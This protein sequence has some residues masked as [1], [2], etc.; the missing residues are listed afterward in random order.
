V[1]TVVA[2]GIWGYLLGAWVGRIHARR[3]PN[4]SDAPPIRLV[5]DSQL[6]EVIG[7][8][9]LVAL[10]VIYRA[11]ALTGANREDQSGYV[12][13]VAQLLIPAYLL[14]LAA[15]R[16][17]VPRGV[18]IRAALAGLAL[19]ASG[20][21]TYTLVLILSL[22]IVWFIQPRTVLQR[23]RAAVLCIAV[24]FTIGIGFGYWRFLREGD[25]SGRELIGSAF[26][27]DAGSA[28]QIAAGFTYVGFFREG[29]AILGFLVE[30]HPKL[31][32]YT[33]GRALW[34]TLTSPLPGQ[35]WD[36]RAIVS[37]EVY[38]ARQTSLVSTIFGPWYLDFGFVGVLLGLAALGYVLSRL[39]E[40]ALRKK[41]HVH[42]AAYAY[43]LVLVGLSIHTGLSDF[44]FAVLIPGTFLWA[45]RSS[46][47]SAP[48][49]AREAGQTRQRHA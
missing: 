1:W 27:A 38:G 20:Y 5:A 26:G 16:A 9:G 25:E 23:A 21:R 12:T 3:T 14:R 2:I 47:A 34:G 35:Q 24:F 22:A 42:Q 30:R 18:W 32:P 33:D 15:T 40:G 46:G 44:V 39:E 11:P 48:A 37:K 8:V 19:L 49:P 43:G 31:E 36:A 10:L 7:W 29:P 28:L 6:L 4:A 13:T 41:S 17:L 45:T